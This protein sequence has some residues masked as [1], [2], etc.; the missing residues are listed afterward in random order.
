MSAR[1]LLKSWISALL[2]YSLVLSVQAVEMADHFALVQSYFP[3]AD[4][5]GEL[6]GEPPSA[7][8]YQGERLLGYV[9]FTDDIIKMPA[10][11]GKPIRTLVGLGL[12]ARITGVTIVHHEEPILV[13]G[14]T[15][16]D[17]QNYN[18]QYLDVDASKR[19]K[20]G[21]AERP[22]Y[23]TIDGLTGATITAIVLNATITRSMREIAISRGLVDSQE[24]SAQETIEESLGDLY[25]TW[26]IVWQERIFKIVVLCLGLLVL[27]M[28]LI[29]QDCW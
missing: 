6:N 16:K 26:V 23:K 27:F 11:S 2:L 8:V 5:V 19:V 4:N 10:Y 15:E 21:G 22:G 28:I 13:T 3:Q 1:Q 17:M 14:I 9:F 12:N 29:F 24:N 18:N 20:I 25:P 7:P